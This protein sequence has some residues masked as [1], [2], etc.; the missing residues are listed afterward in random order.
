MVFSLGGAGVALAAAI[1]YLT[2]YTYLAEIRVGLVAL[3][4]VSCAFAVR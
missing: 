1:I 2:Q 3:S 4:F